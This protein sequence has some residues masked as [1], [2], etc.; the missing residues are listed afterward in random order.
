MNDNITRVD[1]C[2]SGDDDTLARLLEVIV[3][4][5]GRAID[6]RDDAGIGAGVNRFVVGRDELS[7][8]VDAWGADLAGPEPLVRRVLAAMAGL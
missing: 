2:H 8:Y 3:E 7:V 1:L 5:G 6:D 4:L